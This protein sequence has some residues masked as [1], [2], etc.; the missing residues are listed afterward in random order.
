MYKRQI[1]EI[2]PDGSKIRM[3][4]SNAVP[5]AD[6][7]FCHPQ[8]LLKQINDNVGY[9]KVMASCG[10]SVEEYAEKLLCSCW[11]KYTAWQAD[12]INYLI[13]ANDYEM[14]FSHVHNV[15]MIGHLCWRFAKPDEYYAEG[16]QDPQKYQAI[17]ERTYREMCIRD[18]NTDG[19]ST[20]CASRSQTG[21]ICVVVIA[22]QK[23]GW[24][25]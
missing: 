3:W 22:C 7:T 6:A 24:N 12:A 1:L 2:A 19:P 17:I 15:D 9:V 16:G 13:Q 23:R 5:Y 21:A 10:G 4:M 14:V 8:T 20:M 18:S 25:N 11:E